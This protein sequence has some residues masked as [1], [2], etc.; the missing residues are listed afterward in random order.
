LSY[1]EIKLGPWFW[2]FKKKR[3]RKENGNKIGKKKK[4][5]FSPS[6]ENEINNF[7]KPTTAVWRLQS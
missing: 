5:L 1:Y 3:K 7:D 6:S 4:K 2:I